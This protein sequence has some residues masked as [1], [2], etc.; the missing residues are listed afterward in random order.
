MKIPFNF[1]DFEA[2]FGNKKRRWAERRSRGN[3]S[4]NEGTEYERSYAVFRILSEAK[5]CQ[6]PGK[7]SSYPGGHRRWSTIC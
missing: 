4:K 2:K 6:Y 5:V 3:R 7:I 1:R